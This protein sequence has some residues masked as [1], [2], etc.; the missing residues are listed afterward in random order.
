MGKSNR[1]RANRA[2]TKIVN[3][4]K[5]YKKKEGMP[6]WLKTLIAGVVAV[7]VLATCILGVISSNGVFGRYN[8]V[9]R[10]DDFKVSSNM[11]AYLYQTQV[12]SFSNSYSDYMQYFSLDTTK[13]FKNQTYG[14]T[15]KGYAYETSM[16]GAFEG[17]WYDYFM[18][19]AVAQAKQ[20]LVFCEEAE[21]RGIE[22]TEDEIAE[23]DMNIATIKSTATM[24]GYSGN[25]YVSSAYGK[26]VNISDVKKVM[27]ISSLASKCMVE[28]QEEILDNVTEDDINEEYATN[29]NDFDLV[30]YSYYGI[31]IS[32][33]DVV[34]EVLG[35]D[36]TQAELKEKAA[37]VLEAYKKKI[38]DAKK[39]INEMGEIKS[40]A[41][42]NKY[43]YNYVVTEAYGTEFDALNL[44]EADVP[45]E[46]AKDIIKKAII[47]AVVAD[48]IADKDETDEVV[49]DKEDG[50]K[51][52]EQEVTEKFA[53]SIDT[54][55][56]K[57]F[58]KAL[59]AKKTY[60]LEKKN[61]VEDDE[62]FE[63]AFESG[64]AA[65]DTKVI[66]EG[67]GSAEGEEI[68]D[69][70]GY[71][72]ATAYILNGPKY[73]D[74]ANTKNIAYMVFT[75]EALAKEAIEL[76]AAE[77]T[78][79]LEVFKKIATDKA[80]A[81]NSEIEDYTKGGLGVDAFDTWLYD[82]ERKPG[83]HTA[84]PIKVDDN[85]YLVGY[86]YEDGEV[87]W[88]VTV[89]GAI[90]NERY[91]EYLTDMEKTYTITVKDKAVDRVNVVK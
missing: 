14:D 25:Q 39:T 69:E 90:A 2:Q 53:A 36:Y 3:P 7:V 17:T 19:Q 62:F 54:L 85:T 38:E 68:I 73:R 33:E 21:Q 50:F 58:A 63:W 5:Q 86:Y 59:E 45:A 47:E 88:K 43:L 49:V 13:S 15:S 82:D 11:L 24:Y 9:V 91:T 37:E 84:E 71:F 10:S 8:A 66:F 34:K 42:F 23:I 27:M 4:V 22:L 26:G 70:D 77:E 75:S 16:L 30:D 29:S 89:K 74:E 28:I 1:I 56:E 65:N 55:K 18:Q 83:D 32:Y 44:D 81:G 48:V 51:V 35:S 78:K 64:R 87:S 31:N 46:A 67:D 57:L 60:V 40:V 52:F 20:M 12:E 61:Y 41:D 80:A 76:F 6:L 72:Y 79:S